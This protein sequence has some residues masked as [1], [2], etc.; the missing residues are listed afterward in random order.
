MIPHASILSLPVR[1]VAPYGVLGGK[2]V[3][4][5]PWCS[6]AS[7]RDSH[8]ARICLSCGGRSLLIWET[9]AGIETWRVSHYG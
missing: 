2:L 4:A 7:V 1:P 9:L 6:A 5:C 3:P 8:T